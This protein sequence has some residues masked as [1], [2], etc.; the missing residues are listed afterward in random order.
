MAHVLSADRA[1]TDVMRIAL[2]GH[3]ATE[4]VHVQVAHVR[5]ALTI[6]KTL[7][8]ELTRA[9]F[10]ALRAGQQI[11]QRLRQRLPHCHVALLAFDGQDERAA[12]VWLRRLSRT[13]ARAHLVVCFRTASV[14]LRDSHDVRLDRALGSAWRGRGA[15]AERW[16]RAALEAARRRGNERAQAMSACRLIECLTDRGGW[17]TAH[18][19]ARAH[20]DDMRDPWARGMLAAHLAEVLI[21]QLE[22]GSAEALLAGTAAELALSG[23]QPPD[24]MSDGWA[25]LRFC[26]GRFDDIPPKARP[27]RA[28][29]RLILDA[30]VAFVRRD[31]DAL[32]ALAREAAAMSG[33]SVSFCVVLFNLLTAAL[34]RDPLRVRSLWGDLVPLARAARCPRL[35]VLGHAIIREAHMMAG[36]EPPAAD[37]GWVRVLEP[38]LPPLERLFVEWHRASSE[39]DRG[40]HAARRLTRAGVRLPEI[41]RWGC[42]DMHLVQAIPILL[43]VVQDAED[44]LATLVAAGAWIRREAGADATAFLDLDR[45][46]VAADEW[47]PADTAGAAAMEPD[48]APPDAG[49]AGTMVILRSVRYAGTVTGFVAVRGPSARFDRL[50]EAASTVAALCGPALRARIDLLHAARV[51]PALAGEILGRSPAV[52]ALRESVARA[53]VTPFPILIEGES[54]T[55]KELVARALHR[56]SPRRDRRFVAV[57]CAALTDELVEAELFGHTRGAFTGAIG[58]RTGLVEDA[59]GGSLFLD[60]VCELSPRAQAKLLRVLQEREVRRVGEN[61]TRA[62][63]VRIVAATNRPLNDAVQHGTFREDLMFR[64]AVIRLRLPA[65]RDRV[66]DIPLLAHASWRA[67]MVQVSKRSVLGPDAVA[68]LCRHTW[69]GNVRE[70]QNVMAALAVI[71]PDRG[72]VGARHVGQVLAASVESLAQGILPLHRTR[73]NFERTEVA[74]ALARHAGKRTMAAKELGM[75]RQGLTKAM[76]RLGLDGHAR[77]AE[78]DVA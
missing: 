21:G 64:L 50:V 46:V 4:V 49:G 55:G 42:S 30:L 25:M 2:D 3:R 58:A 54:G 27:D 47:T 56:L 35:V 28:L 23:V 71:S 51:T 63:D 9:G 60:E 26:Q 38:R 15:A 6:A 70:L 66:E 36:V 32:G 52:V 68:Q 29:S 48:G 31:R 37:L 16:Y 40:V 17:D 57:N 12:S 53:A 19:V 18:R 41:W 65:L 20:L 10:V 75:T 73:A 62:V 14:P 39:R 76:K 44:D 61:V 45:T 8:A 69:P 78:T 77:G 34:A 67:L 74:G 24:A 33:P 72:R 11:G 43:Q 22:L 59:H 13:S 7:S 5:D 1:A